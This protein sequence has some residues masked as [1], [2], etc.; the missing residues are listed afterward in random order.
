M[1]RNPIAARALYAV[2]LVLMFAT[3]ASA[4]FVAHVPEP[5]TTVLLLTAAGGYLLHRRR[6][7]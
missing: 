3:T 4:D 6:Q 2:G 7:K 1:H 5:T